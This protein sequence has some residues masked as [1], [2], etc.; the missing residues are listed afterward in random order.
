MHGIHR[1]PQVDEE[2]EELARTGLTRMNDKSYTST[3]TTTNV[4]VPIRDRYDAVLRYACATIP[5]LMRHRSLSFSLKYFL[6]LNLKGNNSYKKSAT[7]QRLK[8]LKNELY[9][10]PR[11]G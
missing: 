6:T 3:Y 4:P 5:Q 9:Y 8:L 10:S 7:H 1:L 11:P 2:V